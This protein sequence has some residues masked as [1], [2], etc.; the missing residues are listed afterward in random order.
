VKDL[1]KHKIALAAVGGAL[2]VLVVGY[3]ALIAPRK[4]QA[5][6][7]AAQIDDVRGQIAVARAEARRRT[8][9]RAVKVADIFTLGRAMP[10][11]A[12]MPD[13]L[14][15]LS[16]VAT[17][18]G[19]TFESITPGVPQPLGLYI[20]L[21]IQLTFSGRFYDLADLLYRLRNLVVVNSQTEPPTLRATGR[22]FTIDSVTFSQGEKKFPQIQAQLTVS[23]YLYAG[24]TSLDVTPAPAGG[25]TTST[26]TAPTGATAASAGVNG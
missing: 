19:I 24:S 25:G 17:A 12:D 16:Q 7:L 18:T 15:Q 9:L 14:L 22:L 26:P 20:Q 11:T 1:G 2:L 13:V 4:H 10:T 5:N 21:P 6:Q 8:T 3:V 23:A